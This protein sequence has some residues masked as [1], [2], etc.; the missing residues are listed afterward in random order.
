MMNRF[1]FCRRCLSGFIV[2]GVVLAFAVLLQNRCARAAEEGDKSLRVV[3]KS[4]QKQI[5][6]S[7]ETTWITQPLDS[8]GYV[9]YVQFL[10]DQAARGTT[11]QNNFEV[12]VRQ[13]FGPD[14]I[15]PEWR[16]EYHARIGI[17]VPEKK[18][19][20]YRGFVKFT[21]RGK[22]DVK[23]ARERVWDEY[24]RILSQ[25]WKA[26]EHPAAD[27]WVAAY[28]TQLD[29]LAEESK[30]AKFYTPYL[31]DDLD[32][33]EPLPSL[34]AM[35]L[36]SLQQQQEIAR[37]L[38]I[39]AMG[40]VASEDLEDAWSDLQAMHR[41]ARHAGSGVILL[42]GLV[43]MAI[44]SLACQAELHVLNS[45]ALTDAL[46]KQF[47]GDL[48][49]LAPLT[50][51]AELIDVGE[52][53]IGLDAVAT[54]ARQVDGKT[55]VEMMSELFKMLKLIGLLSEVQPGG[56]RIF[57]VSTQGGAENPSDNATQSPIDWNVTLQVLNGWYDR[58]VAANNRETDYA[59]R[60]GL[61]ETL[62]Q[63]LEEV[64]TDVPKSLVVES[65][66]AKGVRKSLGETVGDVLVTT[67][68]PEPKAVH[69]A[70]DD[71]VARREIIR[72]GFAVELYCRERGNRPKS[73]AVLAPHYVNQIPSDP[74]SGKG[75]KYV[76]DDG[77]WLVYSVGRN[78]VDEQGR[79]SM[80][81]NQGE[82]AHEADD[83][84]VRAS[85]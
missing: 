68:L 80:D 15:L 14:E 57:F 67:L 3:E 65:L 27:A 37:G 5:R 44:E 54:M 69:Q 1:L 62:E 10:N 74:H 73:L 38:S 12:I 51:L 56:E 60:Q 22:K 83:L 8:K 35:L 40:R 9:D 58:L 19:R 23:A 50:P 2:L 11:P 17:P 20:F 48:N 21:L 42:E 39:R 16:A 47:L 18:S 25:P 52:R 77:E 36:P 6:I 30:R 75:L 26:S 7:K 29:Q 41:V 85:D 81:L 63:D 34:L 24:D 70:E 49:S 4:P 28:K 32:A 71:V 45:P 55:H 13:V 64:A 82:V 53:L 33:E 76:V 66:G 79:N 84:A 78:G 72:L 59:I 46:A 61:M 31:A 43:A